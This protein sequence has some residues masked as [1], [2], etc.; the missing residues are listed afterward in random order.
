[1]SQKALQKQIALRAKRR[2]KNVKIVGLHV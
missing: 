2:F 1:L